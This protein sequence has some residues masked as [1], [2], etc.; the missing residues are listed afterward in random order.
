MTQILKNWEESRRESRK[1][2]NSQVS[3]KTQ[4]EGMASG[5]LT[6]SSDTASSPKLTIA[7]IRA[8]SV[9]KTSI[10]RQFLS[11]QF[12]DHSTTLTPV[13]Y[14]SSLVSNNRIIDI[15]VCDFP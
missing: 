15:D 3:S 5:H 1:N 9:G 12:G 4:K 8:K 11:N 10:I 7:F 13:R 6:E 2:A 14:Q